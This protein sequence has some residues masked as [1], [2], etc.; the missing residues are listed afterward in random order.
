MLST[1]FRKLASEVGGENVEDRQTEVPVE[2]NHELNKEVFENL[3]WDRGIGSTRTIY[4][5]QLI[6]TETQ[7]CSPFPFSRSQ[8][9]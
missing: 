1:G 6:L 5:L 2:S 3:F 4:I 7:L 8:S 9:R